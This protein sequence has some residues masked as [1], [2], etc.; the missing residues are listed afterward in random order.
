LVAEEGALKLV[1]TAV[2]TPL[3]GLLFGVGE[4]GF[5]KLAMNGAYYFE[6]DPADDN[7]NS[8]TFC[9]ISQ[10]EYGQTKKVST[11]CRAS[12]VWSKVLGYTVGATGAAVGVA[13]HYTIKGAVLGSAWVIERVAIGVEK[14]TVAVVRSPVGWPL[15]QTGKGIRWVWR[16]MFTDQD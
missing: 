1:L 2:G 15:R 8:G 6:Y 10:G 13:A 14:G 5:K 16:A 9:K 12:V 4:D 3:E 11:P 7:T